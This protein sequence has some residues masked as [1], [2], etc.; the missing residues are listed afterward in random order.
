ML[1]HLNDG[2]GK[3][4]NVRRAEIVI[5]R[6]ALNGRIITHGSRIGPNIEN[7]GAIPQDTPLNH[8]FVG[9]DRG[10]V[11]TGRD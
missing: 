2:L 6:N 11:F 8:A 9:C 7:E 4:V 10:E 5:S 3:I 1:R